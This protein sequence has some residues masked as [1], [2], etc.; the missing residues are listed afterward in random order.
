MYFGWRIV[1][2]GGFL[3]LFRRKSRCLLMEAC[4]PPPDLDDG[5]PRGKSA[6]LR[7]SQVY[8]WAGQGAAG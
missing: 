3:L 8:T 6:A 2:S 1:V 4:G 5:P 7:A